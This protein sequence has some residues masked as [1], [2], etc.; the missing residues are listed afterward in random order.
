MHSFLRTYADAGADLQRPA[1]VAVVMPTILRETLDEALGSIFTQ[2]LAGRIQVLLGIDGVPDLSILERACAGRPAHCVVQVLQPG[3]STAARNDG[4]HRSGDG[5][6]LRAALT[7]LANSRYVA[8]L[9]DD[10]WYAP[11]HLRL[12]RSAISDAE[13]AYSLRW[14]VHPA[15]RRPICVDTWESVG[16]DRG[17]YG[18]RFG[19]FVDTNC[20]MV[21]KL[22][23]PHATAWWNI[24][25][26]GDSRGRGSDRHVFAFLRAYHR[27]GHTARPTVYYRIDA[28][29]IMHGQR[30]LMMGTAYDAAGAK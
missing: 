23:C 24:A 4:L 3:Y 18:E 1:E 30:L 26:P 5:G 25:F 22:A 19:G 13:W 11:D 15:S 27:P 29:D 21:D 28:A 12:M 16:P 9:D 2:D 17:I 6:S 20:L 7:L 10:N 8:Y 14:F